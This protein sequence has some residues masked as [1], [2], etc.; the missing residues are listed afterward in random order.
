MNIQRTGDS[1]H[2]TLSTGTRVIVIRLAQA[3]IRTAFEVKADKSS[4]TK[5]EFDEIDATIRSELGPS[6]LE[7]VVEE[8]DASR[9]AAIANAFVLGGMEKN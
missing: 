9:A 5:G 6:D 8:H 1:W 3:G 7:M 4:L 2:F